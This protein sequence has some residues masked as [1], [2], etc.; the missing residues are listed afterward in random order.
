MSLNIG[1]NCTVFGGL[2]DA[3]KVY[4]P[5]LVFL[6]ELIL[7]QETFSP[8]VARFGFDVAVSKE[9]DVKNGIAIL[10]RR[11]LPVGPVCN[12]ELG[13]IQTIQVMGQTFVNIYGPSGNIVGFARR[14][15]FGETLVGCLS[16]LVNYILL[17]DFNCIVARQD[18]EG[19]YDNKKCKTLEDLIQAQ[20]WVDGF[21]AKHPDTVAYTWYCPHLFAARLDRVYLSRRLLPSLIDVQ[22]VSSHSDHHSVRVS[23]SL[24]LGQVEGGPK[25]A[26]PYWKL[27]TAIL[28]EEEFGEELVEL[29]ARLSTRKAEFSDVAD[30]WDLAVKPEI[31]TLAKVYSARRCRIRRDTMAAWHILLSMALDAGHWEEV[32]LLRARMSAMWLE[33]SWGFVVR[34]RCKESS[35]VEKASLYHMN[36]ERQHSCNNLDKLKVGDNI[37]SGRANVE[38][39]I[40]GFFQPLFSGYHAAGEVNTGQTFTSDPSNL[41]EFLLPLASLLPGSAQQ[42]ELPI[43]PEEVRRAVR[44][45]ARWKSP[46]LDGLPYELYQAY[47]DLFVEELV[48]V[49]NCILERLRLTFSMTRGV[50]R[51][52]PKVQ[53][54]P[55]V[56]ELRPITLNQTDYKIFTKILVFRLVPVLPEVLR[57]GQLC[58]VKGRNIVQGVTAIL[59]GVI[60]VEEKKELVKAAVLSM[61]QWKAFDRVFIWF[62]L[63]VMR[64]MGFGALFISWIQ[65]L[66]TGNSTRFILGS[67]SAPVDIV[68]SV[69]QGDPIALVLYLIFVE[70]LMLQIRQTVPGLPVGMADLKNEPYVD[71]ATMLITSDHQLDLVDDLFR[72]FEGVSGAILN[73]SNKSK[74]LGL[75]QWEGRRSWPLPWLKVVD[76]LKVL[77]VW[78]YPSYNQIVG[79][80]YAKLVA[81]LKKCLL[82][83][84]CRILSSLK[85]RVEVIHTFALSKLWY[86]AQILPLPQKQLLEIESAVRRFLWKD[87]HEQPTL[88]TL[89][90]PGKKGGLGLVDIGSK[91]EALLSRTAL[92]LV[93]SPPQSSYFRLAAY[94]FGISLRSQYPTLYPGPNAVVVPCYFTVMSRLLKE[95]AA[96]E[97]GSWAGTTVKA[98]YQAFT[99]TFP[100]VTI[101]D[102]RE[103]V[104]GWDTVWRRLGHPVLGTREHDVMFRLIHNVLPTRARLHR[105]RQADHPFCLREPLHYQPGEGPREED[106]TE[107]PSVVVGGLFHDVMHQYTSCKE[108]ALQWEMIR[109]MLDRLLAP[110]IGL[111]GAG[112]I[113]DCHYLFLDFVRLSATTTA[114]VIWL[115]GNYVSIMWEGRRRD[116]VAS[117]GALQCELYSRYL[118]HCHSAAVPLKALSWDPT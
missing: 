36:R 40:L 7:S 53:S 52:L 8:L 104:E 107:A 90:N 46:G 111:A 87:S 50:T 14:K 101:E 9:Q 78:L 76:Q 32:S 109:R 17:G 79:Q 34:S 108:V 21:R 4:K 45:M 72:R 18:T 43:N 37:V 30:W 58:S 33:D 86:I 20:D 74:I 66:H 47:L 59:S 116:R 93:H 13:R 69:R 99:T 67:L 48:A 96:M 63:L 95:L 2:F 73:C 114:T 98:I 61:D 6:Q 112:A 82:E 35:E 91:A 94:Y 81:N 115:V 113:R 1:G 57:S 65:M 49:F 29:M 92:R 106:G 44:S 41:P 19:H 118:T 31:A 103:S 42:L 10:W 24:S 22:H 102:K 105:C 25:H 85:Q 83:W 100:P 3:L 39:A 110:I 64:A 60:S 11:E 75:G 55:T 16:P 88:D 70:P 62:L 80:N 12:I 56:L 23:F 97:L 77:G 51:L 117:R 5:H 54:I 26:M 89:K 27:N 38:K 84:G 15:L 68:F 28:K 71:D